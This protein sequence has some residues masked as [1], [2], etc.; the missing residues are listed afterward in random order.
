MWGESRPP[1]VRSRQSRPGNTLSRLS[2]SPSL[3]RL[4]PAMVDTR[5]CTGRR[6]KPSR[7]PRPGRGDSRGGG[8]GGGTLRPVPSEGR[9]GARDPFGRVA[10]VLRRRTPAMCRALSVEDCIVDFPGAPH[11]AEITSTA[12]LA[13]FKLRLVGG[14]VRAFVSGGRYGLV[15]SPCGHLAIRPEGNPRRFHHEPES[16]AL[17]GPGVG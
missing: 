1:L 3:R 6:A 16:S 14:R 5:V 10:T 4:G 11:R 7:G 12:R 8:R 13:L 2:G 17:V 15:R 9:A